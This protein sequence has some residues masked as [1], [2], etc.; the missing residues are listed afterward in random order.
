MLAVGIQGTKPYRDVKS[1]VI[2]LF[3]SVT[4]AELMWE[5]SE[6]YFQQGRPSWHLS[7]LTP[8]DKSSRG[9]LVCKTQSQI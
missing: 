3:L 9:P 8:P 2:S 1:G 4:F 5:G 6:P 7:T